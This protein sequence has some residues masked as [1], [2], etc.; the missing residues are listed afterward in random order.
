MLSNRHM[1]SFSQEVSP[2]SFLPAE[3]VPNVLKPYLVYLRSYVA[4]LCVF[5]Y[6][7]NLGNY[8]AVQ[9]TMSY[10]LD[11]DAP[12]ISGF[13]N[14]LPQ[15]GLAIGSIASSY[16]IS[17]TTR[18]RTL[19]ASCLVGM[20]A[21]G[22][23]QYPF[24]LWTLF[25]GRF[26]VGFSYAVQVV[27]VSLYI[28]EFTPVQLRGPCLNVIGIIFG[29]GIL[30]SFL[31]SLGLKKDPSENTHYWR[32]I[33]GFPIVSLTLE[34][35]LLLTVYRDD[36]PFE[37]L[38]AQ[39]PLDAERVLTGL[40]ASQD[41]SAVLEQAQRELGQEEEN[42]PFRSLFG[43]YSRQL[44]V[45]TVSLLAQS[46]TGISIYT[47]YST[48]I[49]AS[50]V[51]FDVSLY[52]SVLQLVLQILFSYVS[53]ALMARYGRK[54][55]FLA[56]MVANLATS[57]AITVCAL[58]Q[59]YHSSTAVGVL[60]IVCIELYSIWCGLAIASISFVVCGEVLPKAGI[61]FAQMCLGTTNCLFAVLFPVST[62]R[63]L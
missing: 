15:L 23:C 12:Y 55:I 32:L 22:L 26:M 57:L 27:T 58:V 3:T 51:D 2:D 56:V 20:L 61:S 5:S 28:R 50:V 46:L 33:L 54:Q 53:S 62:Q 45:G 31:L 18:R 6:A 42:V 8:N 21:N 38:R 19:I 14:G 24:P 30:A 47:S 39:Q 29:F 13:A 49:F 4:C 16:L 44:I 36:T 43:E 37:Y 63:A 10:V 35:V 1:S 17:F 52:L 7:N 41:V 59:N 11:D 40:Y 34:V 25:L 48:K 9:D 60:M